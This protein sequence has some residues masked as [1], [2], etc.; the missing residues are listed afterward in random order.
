LFGDTGRSLLRFDRAAIADAEIW[1][2]VSGHFAH[3]GA[4]HFWLNAFGLFL[5]WF[6]VGMRFST[7]EWLIV[8]IVSIISID[9]GL[10][11]F[12]PEL[13][14]YVGMSGLLHG[15]LVAGV[16]KGL[17]AATGEALVIGAAVLLKILFEQWIG[18]LPGSES[19]VGGDVVVNV[20]LYGTLAGAVIAAVFWIRE[21]AKSP[22]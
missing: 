17:H 16:V 12:D 5:V 6:L 10:W 13:A 19:S 11:L 1:R 7:R 3:L 20:H 2:L 15:I 21:P 14:W 4:G 9:V 8:A 22:L 18:P